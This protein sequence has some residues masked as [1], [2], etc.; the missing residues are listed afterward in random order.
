MNVYKLEAAIDLNS[1]EYQKGLK[2][3]GESMAAL[4]SKIKDGAAAIGKATAA[5]MAAGAAG[6]AALAKSAVTAYADFEQLEGGVKKLF[7]TASD[8]LMSYAEQ[9]YITSG[10]SANEYMEQATSFSASLISS[11]KGDVNEAAKLTDLAMRSMSDNA[12]TFGTDLSS[13]QTAYQG[14]AKEQYQLL[15]NL[16]LGYGGTKT[17][18]ERLIADANEYADSIGEASDLTIDSYADQI[19]AIDLIQ[20]KQKI[21]G[22]TQKEALKTI[23][24]SVTTLKAA[25][26]DF[27][28]ELGKDN[29]DIE[30]G[31]ANLSTSLSAVGD[32]II[33]RVQTALKSI[34]NVIKTQLPTVIREI[35][36]KLGEILPSLVTTGTELASALGSGLFEALPTVIKQ[37]PEAVEWGSTLIQ[38]IAN[39]VLNADYK[40][41]GS[42]LSTAIKG[43]L[44]AVTDVLSG[45]DWE[46]LG[47]DLGD[48]IKNIDWDGIVSKAWEVIKT[49]LGG[50][51]DVAKGLYDSI[52]LDGVM[53]LIAVWS[54]PKFLSSFASTMKTDS[55]CQQSFNSIHEMLGTDVGKKSGDKAGISYIDAF[56]SAL[57]VG[58][59]T[60]ELTDFIM[61]NVKWDGKTLRERHIDNL[62]LSDGGFSL[63]G[64]ALESIRKGIFDK[65]PESGKAFVNGKVIDVIKDSDV[66]RE[67]GIDDDAFRKTTHTTAI[68]Q[69][70]EGGR[71]THPT[72]A[73]VGEKEPETI[74]PD[75]KR[76]AFGNT[77]NVTVNIDGTGK[78][79]EE[80]ADEAIEVLSSKFAYLGIKQKRAVGGV[81]W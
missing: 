76:G 28:A 32:N 43:G 72:L 40:K 74:V 18:M 69:Y 23:S 52:G 16:K 75:S 77:Y 67:H 48:F 25:W 37:L 36:N 59:A 65:Q 10:I 66:Y 2:S 8:S 53:D 49:A 79:A 24:G 54:A 39:S 44:S 29:G 14:F 38:K 63:A 50:L 62:T 41:L 3:A 81:G 9:A 34:G 7:G 31:F 19:K 15:D 22:T 58:F 78:N 20:R 61:D 64:L 70:A 55:G 11:L 13:I 47:T 46:K 6:V 27:T 51:K 80:I 73:I 1:T 71:V 57:A 42:S 33:P 30:G 5:G 12:N 17:E 60:F 35:P 56:K 26:K 21:A 68:P 45:I 4:G